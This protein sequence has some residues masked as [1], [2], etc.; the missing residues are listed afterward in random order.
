MQAERA[1]YVATTVVP[2]A[3]EAKAQQ[4]RAERDA[5]LASIVS[6]RKKI[7][8]AADS[9]WPP[10]RAESVQARADFKLPL[11]R[12]YSYREFDLSSTSQRT[13]A[14]GLRA[15]RSFILMTAR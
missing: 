7:Q 12:P 8:Y 5:L 11:T 1:A 2:G 13:R 10:R 9:L 14:A 4:N 15:G 3:E 6:R